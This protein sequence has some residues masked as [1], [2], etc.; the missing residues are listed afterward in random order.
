VL[1]PPITA[2]EIAALR[3]GDRQA[4]ATVVTAEQR[5]VF[6]IA[7]RV[8]GNRAEADEIAQEAFLRLYRHASQIDS[9]IHLTHWMRQVTVRLAIDRLRSRPAGISVPMEEFEAPAEA[10]PDL[11][12]MRRLRALVAALPAQARAVITL[13]YQEDLDPTTIAGMLDMPLNTVKS[14]LKRALD[15]LHRRLSGT[16]TA[17]DI[18]EAP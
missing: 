12:L 6:G 13:R 4:F 3:R 7:L 14:H 8:L 18:D 10:T 17:E 1:N 5:R 2:V 9:P 11:L 15:S 16:M